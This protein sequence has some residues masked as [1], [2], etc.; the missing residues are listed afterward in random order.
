LLNW[1]ALAHHEQGWFVKDQTH[2]SYE[3]SEAYVNAIKEKL[4]TTP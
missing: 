2:L 4:G 1:D 3:G